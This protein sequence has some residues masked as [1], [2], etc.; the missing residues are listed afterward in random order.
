[1]NEIL[2]F[3]SN[4]LLYKNVFYCHKKNCIGDL[5]NY[6]SA[7]VNSIIHS[8]NWS[9]IYFAAD[10]NKPSWRKTVY[11]D[12]KGT[13]VKS[14]EINWKL[15]FEIYQEWL[16]DMGKEYTLLQGD[17]VEGD[18]WILS[19]VK[20][21]NKLHKSCWIVANDRDLNQLLKYSIKHNY[22]NI[23]IDAHFTK[24]TLMLPEGWEIYLKHIEQFNSDVF[25]LNS[26]KTDWYTYITTAIARSHTKIDVN[27][28]KSLFVKLL[29][30]DDSDNIN[31]IHRSKT[32]TGKTRELGDATALKVWNLFTDN[33][34]EFDLDDDMFNVNVIMCLEELKKVKFSKHDRLSINEKLNFN[35]SLI[36]LNH[37]HYPEKIINQIVHTIQEFE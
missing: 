5:Y 27:P 23:Q 12:Y 6:M 31:S 1:M 15:V 18:D 35:K 29:T 19:I 21:Q 28:E 17:N 32:S 13:R 2:I 33:K 37:K 25:N 3:D 36:E 34:Y 22:I 7:S 4:Y 26:N 10:S 11:P 9:K 24:E 30:G 8:Y 20:R 16:T 14:D